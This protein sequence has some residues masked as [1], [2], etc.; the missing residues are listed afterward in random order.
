MKKFLIGLVLSVAVSAPAFA[1]D[2]DTVA[3][4]AGQIMERRQAGIPIDRVIGDIGV[5]ELAVQITHHAYRIRQAT[6]KPERKQ[7]VERFSSDY[8]RACSA[9]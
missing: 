1:L 6:Y 9:M 8:Y 3:K 4:V 5:S 7:A 2:C